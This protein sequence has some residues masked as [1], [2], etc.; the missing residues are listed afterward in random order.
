[1][2]IGE[3]YYFVTTKATGHQSRPKYHL[4]IGELGWRLEGHGFL[5]INKNNLDDGYPL[6]KKDY[7][8]FPL[9]VSFVSGLVGYDQQELDD[10]KL[11]LCGQLSKTHLSELYRAVSNSE[12]LEGWVIREVCQKL[13]PHL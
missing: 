3:I 5:F 8:F 7:E 6:Y 9:E 12:F 2:K 4:Y 13:M 10:S 11:K 1:M